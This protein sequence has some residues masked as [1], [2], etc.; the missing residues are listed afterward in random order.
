MKW[1]ATILKSR[2]CLICLPDPSYSLSIIWIPFIS[3]KSRLADSSSEQTRLQVLERAKALTL[4]TSY[5]ALLLV[6]RDLMFLNVIRIQYTQ[7]FRTCHHS[8]PFCLGCTFAVFI[9]LYC[10]TIWLQSFI[11]YWRPLP[12]P[13]DL[14]M[15][16]SCLVAIPRLHPDPKGKKVPA[17]QL[18]FEVLKDVL[19]VSWQCSGKCRKRSKNVPTRA[20]VGS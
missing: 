11:H 16:Q 9:S 14:E 19:L 18:S 20:I 5:M 17:W 6:R 15:S 12:S 1:S 2:T 7:L 8:H 4:S 13:S 3:L 10:I